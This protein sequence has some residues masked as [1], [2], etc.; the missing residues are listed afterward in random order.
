MGGII[1]AVGTA[2][3]AFALYSVVAY[4]ASPLRKFPGPFLAGE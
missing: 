1:V 3:V 2:L 4:A